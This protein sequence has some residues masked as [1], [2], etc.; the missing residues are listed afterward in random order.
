MPLARI[1]PALHIA[2]RTVQSDSALNG[3]DNDGNGHGR[4]GMKRTDQQT[5]RDDL[6]ESHAQAVFDSL[7]D[8]M[9]ARNKGGLGF[10]LAGATYWLSMTVAGLLL[11]QRWASVALLVGTAM[12]V[13]L[14]GFL[15][16]RFGARHA[17]YRNPVESTARWLLTAQAM[18][19]PVYLIVFTKIPLYLP[20]T[21]SLL[22][23]TPFGV[24]GYLYRSK[25]YIHVAILRC[26][27]CSIFMIVPWHSFVAVP[28]LTAATYAYAAAMVTREME[29]GD[30]H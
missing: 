9:A 10:L 25:T 12:I 4:Q 15:S 3:L 30:R 17:S 24:L 2:D 27:L 5:E 28:L 20:Q 29:Q 6:P 8:D 26:V 18:F 16:R 11:S 13:P 7:R 1:G 22:M 23:A 14:A 19:W 21:M